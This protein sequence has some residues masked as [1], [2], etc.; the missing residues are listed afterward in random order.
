MRAFLRKVALQVPAVR[1]L[2][3]ERDRLAAA[4]QESNDKGVAFASE[5]DRL[6]AALAASQQAERFLNAELDR[7]VEA[8]QRI[9][10]LEAHGRILLRDCRTDV[11]TV[12]DELRALEVDTAAIRLAR[13]EHRLIMTDYAYHPESRPI[14][15]RAGGQQIIARFQRDKPAIA[16]TIRS[17]ARYVET[18]GRIAVKEDA[19]LAPYWDNPW[20]AP[21][22][23]A[24]LYG[25]VAETKPRRYV[26]VGSGISTR[27]ARQAISD[28]GLS[29][30]IVSIDPH[31]HNAVDGLCDEIIVKRAEDLHVKFWAELT[32]DDMLFI[33]NSHRCLPGSDVTVFFTEIMPSLPPGVLYGIHDIFLPFDYPREWRERFYSEQYLLMTY[34]LGGGGN[35]EILLPIR[36]AFETPNLHRILEP[37]WSRSDLFAGLRT[38][39][40]A[41]WARRGRNPFQ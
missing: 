39:G 41:F 24:A 33:D 32:K 2:F 26:E 19:S 37:L 7:M 36:W 3:D 4:L 29:T 23:G 14:E 27:F 25:L 10:D 30:T 6:S 17:V 31:P 20:F 13:A 16:E 21:F 28:F 22:D 34:L 38:N 9:S 11:C 35:D 18:L 12:T 1:R 8:V 40:G 15:E 5:Q